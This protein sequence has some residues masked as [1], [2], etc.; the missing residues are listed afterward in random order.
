MRDITTSKEKLLKKVR[1]ALLEKRDNP[2]PNL[3]DL[4]MYPP[5]EELPEVVFA[6]QFTAVSGQFV[7]CEDEVQFIENLLELAEERKWHKIYCWEP[8]LQQVLATYEYPYFETDKDFEQ[9]EVGF[10]LCEALIARNG[11]IMLSNANAA[12]RRLSIYPPVHI[13][14]AYTS[15]LVLDLKD[16]LKL[17][18]EKYSTR[19]PSMITTI[20]GPSRTADIEKT[21]VLGAHGPKELFVFLLDG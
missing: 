2:Y 3:E 18:K 9:A 21:L 7:F 13:V 19:L 12:G 5:G 6:E 14:L 1:K 20:T 15:Q 10:T 16:A 11:S 17:M 8:A 4:P